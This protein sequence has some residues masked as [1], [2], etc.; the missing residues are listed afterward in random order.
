MLANPNNPTGAVLS[1]RVLDRLQNQ[2]GKLLIDE[3]YIDFSGER[4]RI[5]RIDE[6]T[7]VFRSLSKAFALAGLRLGLLFGAETNMAPIK[8]RQW[9]CNISV[10]ALEAIRAVLRD[11]YVSDH[12]ARIAQ[13]REDIQ[14]A[15]VEL[16]FGVGEGFSNFALIRHSDSQNL[17]RFLDSHGICVLDT[18]VVGLEEH[19]RISVGTAAE[20]DALIKALRRYVSQFGIRSGHA[21]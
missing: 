18:T 14:S 6:R 17:M 10:V 3:A 19:V 20:N 9:F 15:A 12:A 1:E 13:G 4:T 2:C 21:A 8:N 5:D 16:G 7:F 11:P